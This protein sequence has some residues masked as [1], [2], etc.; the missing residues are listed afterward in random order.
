[1]LAHLNVYILPML[2]LKKQFW[3]YSIN[4]FTVISQICCINS[5][6][7]TVYYNVDTFKF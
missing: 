7:I 6:G 5:T 1:M 4:Q 3:N 2:L